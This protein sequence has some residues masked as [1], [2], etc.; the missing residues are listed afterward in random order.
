MVVET[1][2]KDYESII[3]EKLIEA[4]CKEIDK[5]VILLKNEIKQIQIVKNECDWKKEL[6]YLFE[7]RSKIREQ[8]DNIKTS[9][10]INTKE[11]FDKSME[12]W[13]LKEQNKSVNKRIEFLEEKLSE[14]NKEEIE[15][16]EKIRY[17]NSLRIDIT[18]SFEM[19]SDDE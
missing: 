6:Q 18:L 16:D 17:L 7:L 19:C 1:T 14:Y 9:G 5:Q 8:A 10:K 11:D 4:Q 3:K 2:S 12:I 13:L 15:I